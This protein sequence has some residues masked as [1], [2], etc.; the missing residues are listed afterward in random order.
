MPTVSI[1]ISTRGTGL[2]TGG[3][4]AVGH[5][6]YKLGGE[7]KSYGFAPAVHGEAFG[8]GEVYF[9]DSENYQST[10]ISLTVNIS[11]AQYD[12]MKAYGENPSAYGFNME[13]NGLSNSC[14]DFT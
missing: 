7:S 1:N 13:Y 14:I 10:E 3:A 6:W 8:P 2:N 9:N 4:S 12:A 5:M 11:Q